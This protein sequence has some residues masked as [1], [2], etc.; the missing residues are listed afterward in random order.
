M[1]GYHFDLRAFVDDLG[2]PTAVYWMLIDMGIPV[3]PRTVN[4]WLERNDIA[5]VYV[6]NLMAHQS[7]HEGPMDLNRY[8]LPA[9]EALVT[10][11]RPGAAPAP[12]APCASAARG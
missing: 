2:G 3:K 5:L 4:K 11:R 6:V 10:P 12:P 1:R 7:L 9:Q 8:I